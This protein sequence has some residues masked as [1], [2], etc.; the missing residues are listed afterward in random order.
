MIL[1][2]KIIYFK[3]IIL[4]IFNQIPKYTQLNINIYANFN[5]NY[6]LYTNYDIKLFKY[7][8]SLNRKNSKWRNI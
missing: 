5:N 1:I 6:L 3:Y 8:N 2:L 4:D 7:L